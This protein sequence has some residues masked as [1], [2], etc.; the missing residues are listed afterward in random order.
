MTIQL[1]TRLA[2]AETVHALWQAYSDIEKFEYESDVQ[3]LVRKAIEQPENLT[4][5]E[6]DRFHNYL[7]LVMS[8]QLSVAVMD[9]K[10]GLALGGIEERAPWLAKRYFSGRF[11]RAWFRE[12]EYW[13]KP[14]QPGF[15]EALSHAI[16]NTPVQT[17]Y[18][19]PDA[20]RSRLKTADTE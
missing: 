19:Y 4:D 17:T 9:K 8:H 14:W 1:S 11:S 16:D 18:N 12:N 20:I 3:T 15:V 5:A 10:Y 6:I 7:T 13:L 2:Q